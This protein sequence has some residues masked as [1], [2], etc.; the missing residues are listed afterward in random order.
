MENVSNK[1]TDLATEGL[2]DLETKLKNGEMPSFD[3][4]ALTG[5]LK[6]ITKEGLGDFTE[7]LKADG[8]LGIDGITD[9]LKGI[10]PDS[11]VEIGAKLQA[12]AIPGIDIESMTGSKLEYQREIE[13]M[14]GSKLQ[15]LT[16]MTKG[17]S[18]AIPIS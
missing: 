9:T 11:L 3:Q 8:M 16:D 15:G 13:R 14:A 5:K 4:E 6:V 1:L 17:F 12:G 7:K 18:T 2:E 10:A